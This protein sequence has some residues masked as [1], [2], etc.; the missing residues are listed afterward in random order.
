MSAKKNLQKVFNG[1]I[2][3]KVPHF[4]LGFHLTEEVFGEVYES[5]YGEE[6]RKNYQNASKKGKDILVG[7]YLELQAKIREKYDWSAIKIPYSR[8]KKAK[9]VLGDKA[10]IYDSNGQGTFWMPTGN[11]MMD[12]TV[13]LFEKKDELFAEAEKKRVASIELAKRQVDAG[14]DFIFIPSDY[15]YNSGPFISPKYFSELVTPNLAKIVEA[16]HKCGVKVILHSDGDLREILDQIVSTGIDGYQ[17]I[18]PQGHMDIA[19][20]KKE[21]GDRLILMG[22]V[23]CSTLQDVNEPEIRRAVQYCMRYGKP[24]GKYIFSS[25]N[26]IFEGMPIESYNIMLDEY[27]KYAYY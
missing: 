2:P 27:E 11:D 21:Y 26:L 17:S 19:Q 10:L 12:F 8:I 7:K 23:K 15:G 16:I 5:Y 4:E 9:K 6:Y 14:A 20:V 24:N 18:D 22:N 1:E 25:S 13:K 3:E